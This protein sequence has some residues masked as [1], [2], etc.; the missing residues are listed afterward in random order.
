[1]NFFLDRNANKRKANCSSQF[2]RFTSK[3]NKTCST[4][5]SSRGNETVTKLDNVNNVFLTQK[6]FG[7]QSTAVASSNHTISKLTGCLDFYYRDTQSLHFNQDSPVYLFFQLVLHH[8]VLVSL[9]KNLYY[10]VRWLLSTDIFSYNVRAQHTCE[11]LYTHECND[12]F[13]ISRFSEFDESDG[14]KDI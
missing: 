1:M 3:S 7:N 13:Y 11:A 5:H 8:A 12:F 10:I 9:A 14:N 6:M 2:R 4:P